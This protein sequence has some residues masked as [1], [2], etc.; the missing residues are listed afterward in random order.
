LVVAVEADDVLYPE[1]LKIAAHDILHF[2]QPVA[3][4]QACSLD[5]FQRDPKHGRV[6]L[7]KRHRFGIITVD[8]DG[9]V[10]IQHQCVPLAQ[11]ISP[12]DLDEELR[13]LNQA[14]RVRFKQAHDS[15]LINAGQ[16]LQ[17][18]GQIVEGLVYSVAKQASARGVTV[19]MSDAL[20]IIIDKLYADS[21]FHNPRAA[22]GG[23]RNF[24][25]KFRNT[26]S[27]APK[28]A[29]D[30][31]IRMNKC[32]TGFLDA[33]RLARQLR[34]PMQILGFKVTLHTT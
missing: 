6:N 17:Q 27:H 5:V 8:E 14:L 25:K 9:K 22:L 34:A 23:I 31:A 2:E 7:L 11:H 19:S 28:T 32:R 30:A 33:I 21:M 10:A 13:G 15:Y 12:E 3:L 24:V 18:A 20:A 16:G 4:Y 29:R 1:A 26:A